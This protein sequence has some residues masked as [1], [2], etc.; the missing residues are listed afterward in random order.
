MLSQFFEL[1]RLDEQA[2]GISARDCYYHEIPKY[3]WW[4]K[5]VN[6]WRARKQI[7]KTVGR[8]HFISVHQGERYYIRLILIHR[9]DILSW[10]DLK[11]A[12]GIIYADCRAA[13]DA[14]GLLRNDVQ[15]D[16]ALKE[17]SKFKTGFQLRLMFAIMLVYSPPA[18][19][20]NLFNGHWL[21]L[22]D[23]LAYTLRTSHG[24][25]DPTHIQL[26]AFTLHQ[27]SKILVSMG[28]HLE[29]VSLAMTSEEVN[30]VESILSA[31]LEEN[32][33]SVSRDDWMISVSLLTVP[34]RQ[35]Y[36]AVFGKLVHQHRPGM[37]YYLDG[38]GGTGKTFLLNCIIEGLLT[39]GKS[40]FAVSSTGVS[41]LLLKGGKTAH[42]GFKIPVKFSAETYCT[43][44]REDQV[45]RELFNTDLI[46]WD[47]AISMHKDAIE[48]VDRSLQDLMK[49]DK[50]FGE[51]SVVFAGDFRQTLPVVKAGVFPR[52][53]AA[54]LKSLEL[55]RGIRVY[56]LKDNIRLGIGI[57]PEESK[58][59]RVFADELLEIGKGTRQTKLSERISLG[60]IPVNFQA[61]AKLCYNL[62]I[63]HVYQSLDQNANGDWATYAR[64]LAERV[65][66]T[67]LNKDACKVN[68]AMLRNLRSEMITSIS[69]NRADDEA[70]RTLPIE[71]LD[72]VDFAGF[73]SHRLELKIGAPIVLLRNLSI[74]QGL[75]NGTRLVIEQLSPRAIKG[76]ILTGPF[77]NSEVLIPKIS[78]FHKGDAVVK[79]S[80]Y[81]YQFPVALSFAMTINKCQGQSMGR[82]ALVLE[83]QP[84]AHGQ[85]YVGLSRVRNAAD[86]LVIQVG[87]TATVTNVVSKGL[88]CEEINTLIGGEEV[89]VEE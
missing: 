72:Q 36:D 22:G 28:T 82:V 10:T 2:L 41:A 58:H 53:E 85:L 7:L 71:A 75:C 24:I 77:K 39:H 18:A 63:R 81:R 46:I 14:L 34:Q 32:S 70:E 84:F 17:G 78:L 3:F 43:F 35:F 68:R 30:V 73:P 27:I 12:H 8:I 16:K 51:K 56:S 29:D 13:A 1:N 52:S 11:S 59:N 26:R 88:F 23:D 21:E 57:S 20:T 9:K 74:Q 19:P 64:Y 89:M 55:W 4:D 62:A 66:L 49:M 54:T 48:A 15:Y 6:K 87:D 67:T 47:E 33:L 5:E 44:T 80:F 65:I 31:K 38:P 69:V 25:A 45:G 40:T 60:N 50:P 79:F 86:L 61:K 37:L 76:R 42:S 83:N